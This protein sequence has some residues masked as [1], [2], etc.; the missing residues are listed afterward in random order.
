MK[1]LPARTGFD[2]LKQGFAL[3]KQQPGILM[4]LIFA[5]FIISMLLMQLSIP[6]LIL[7]NPPCHHSPWQSSSRAV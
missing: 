7:A 4:M 1:G 3:F 6:G 2:W 5:N